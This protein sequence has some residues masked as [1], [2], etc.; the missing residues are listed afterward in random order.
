MGFKVTFEAKYRYMIEIHRK[1]I[2]VYNE[3]D[4]S[5]AEL[6]YDALMDA[7]EY[8]SFNKLA[9][10]GIKYLFAEELSIENM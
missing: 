9:L 1:T 2:V 4:I 3:G 10:E 6:W 8:G 5:F 7:L